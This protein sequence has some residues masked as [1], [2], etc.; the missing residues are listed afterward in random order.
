MQRP[1]GFSDETL[2]EFEQRGLKRA[3]DFMTTGTA[4]AYEHG[5]RASTIGHVLSS[6]P[7]ALLAW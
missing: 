5:T 4:Y 6:N 7:I 1:K 2:N 3:G